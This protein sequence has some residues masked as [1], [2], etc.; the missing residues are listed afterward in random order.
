MPGDPEI[1]QVS[2]AP[3]LLKNTFTGIR[4]T[5]P[6]VAIHKLISEEFLPFRKALCRRPEFQSVG[7]WEQ[8]VVTFVQAY[9]TKIRNSIVEVTSK[10]EVAVDAPLAERQAALNAHVDRMIN[11]AETLE[12]IARDPLASHGDLMMQPATPRVQPLTFNW[13]G[14]DADYPQ[15]TPGRYQDPSARVLITG[16]DMCVVEMTNSP[17]SNASRTIN[18]YDASIWIGWLADLYNVARHAATNQNPYIPE[19][20][21]RSQYDNIWNADGSKDTPLGSGDAQNGEQASTSNRTA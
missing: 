10:D 9:L 16:L 20:L 2:S 7:L 6:N 17:S 21:N 11:T 4:S 5:F 18:R 19:G 15:P 3:G 13:S 12:D 1:L 8:P 14:N